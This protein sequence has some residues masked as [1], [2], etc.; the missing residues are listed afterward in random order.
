MGWPGRSRWVLVGLGDLAPISRKGQIH[1]VYGRAPVVSANNFTHSIEGTMKMTSLVDYIL[2]LF[3]S[4][5]AARSFV[6][7]SG[8]AMTNAGLVNVSPVEIS[9]AAA[10][11]LP[12][13]NLGAGDRLGDCSKR[14]RTNTACAG[15]GG[16]HRVELRCSRC[17]CCRCSRRCRGRE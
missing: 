3:R 12:F 14:W 9:S 5:D 15:L 4:E 1:S 13:L 16:G 10:N 17:G 8:Q 7:S 2:S 11:A 6:A